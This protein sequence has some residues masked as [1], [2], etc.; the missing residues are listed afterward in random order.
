[1]QQLE[2][3]TPIPTLT[4]LK[5]EQWLDLG[6][7]GSKAKTWR[8][9]KAIARAQGTPLLLHNAESTNSHTG[10]K[11]DAF[12]ILDII[13]IEPDR[14]RG[15]QACMTDWQPHIEKLRE[16]RETCARWL[17]PHLPTTLELWGWRKVKRGGRSTWRPRVQLITLGFLD[18]IEEPRMLEVFADE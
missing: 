12:G 4:L 9:V 14:I 13:A 6:V 7:K 2:I 3:P 11:S 10:Y 5:K 15:I 17:S 18:G 1:M 16:H 8:T